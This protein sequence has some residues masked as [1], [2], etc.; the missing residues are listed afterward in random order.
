MD[1]DWGRQEVRDD[2]ALISPPWLEQP[3]QCAAVVVVRG[4]VP[5][6]RIDLEIDGI[7]AVA[8]FDGGLPNPGGAVI[9]LP[10]ALIA[11]QKLRARQKTAA[12]ESDWS[13]LIPALDHKAAF[14]QGLPRPVIDPAPVHRCGVR[15]GVNNL[16]VG[17]EVWIEAAGV[18]VGRHSGANVQQ[19]VNVDPAY[20]PD[21]PV[22]AFA[23]LCGDL[24]QPSEEKMTQP[25]PSPVPALGFEPLYEGGRQLVVN[26]VVNGGVIEISRN[27]TAFF[28]SASFGQRHLV[29]LDP[30]G[31][32]SDEFSG[33]QRL[34]PGDPASPKSGVTVSACAAL[35]APGVAPVKAGDTKLTLTGF[36]PDAVIKV[37]V[38]GTKTGEGSGPVVQLTQPVPGGAI[39]LVHQSTSSCESPRARQLTTSCLASQQGA[40]PSQT[41]VSA[42]GFRSYD[43][44]EFQLTNGGAHR[45]AGTI[46]YPAHFDGEGKPFNHAAIGIHAMPIVFMAHGNAA[47]VLQSHLGYDYFQRQL[48]GMGIIAVSVD[49]LGTNGPGGS[50]TNILDRA[51]L[52]EASIRYWQGSGV[53][54]GPTDPVDFRNIGLMGHSRGGEAVLLVK[55][56]LGPFEQELGV[57]SVLSLAPT[58]AGA[59]DGVPAGFDFMTIVP[60]GDGDVVR[61]DGIAYYDSAKPLRFKSQLYIHGANHNYFNR[62]WPKDD[63]EGGLSLMTRPDHERILSAYGCAFFRMTLLHHDM[64]GYFDGSLTPAGVEAGNVHLSLEVANQVT[65]DDHEQGN[66]LDTNTMGGATGKLDGLAADEHPFAQMPGAFNGSFYGNSVGMVALSEGPGEFVSRLDQPRDLGLGEVWI[67]AAEVYPMRELQAGATGFALGLE[68]VN[69]VVAWVD[70]DGIGGLPRPY[71]RRAWDVTVAKRDFRDFSKTVLKTLRF[72]AGCFAAQSERGFDISQVAAIRLRL[73]RDDGRPLAFDDLQIVRP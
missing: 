14:P 10:A 54:W 48:A 42:V 23:S 61:N 1:V 15:T 7:V 21:Q 5:D 51:K 50:A 27:G 52:I 41:S 11:G 62:E 3:W 65:V 58:N 53:V 47:A 32:Q 17:C 9:P 37:F 39:V 25:P 56:L 44:G 6:A 29:T 35:P 71:D 59:T 57:R 67:R 28:A 18:E 73:D 22:V 8:D 46:Y 69:G 33:H 30:P 24:S 68:D 55:G 20:G 12:A 70:C 31:T 49:C 26:N 19:G 4:Y 36:V 63:T 38:N 64:F 34:C 60:A 43:A 16:L 40:D 13:P 2:R 72:P 45:I 66:T